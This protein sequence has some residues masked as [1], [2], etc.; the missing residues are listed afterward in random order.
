M[1]TK[2]MNKLM[3]HLNT[4][5]EQ[6]DPLVLHSDD[7]EPHIDIL[8]YEPTE[9]Y[10]FWK[11]TTMGASDFKMNGNNSLGNRNEYM[12]FIDADEDLDDKETLTWYRAQL[13]K[14]A[15]YPVV[16]NSFIS[17]FHSVEW[18]P[19]AG[20]EM[21]CAYLEFPQVIESTGILRCKLGFSKTAICLLAI[22]L[23]KTETEKLLEIGPQQFSEYLYPD[24][25]DEE[26]HFLSQRKR[27]DR[28]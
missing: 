18:S 11:L 19:E 17:V 3:D 2:E 14:V 26:M 28:F 27:N 24:S 16:N 12:M 22:L 9:K 1:K 6:G 4:Y 5:F 20:E 10:H 13:L 7:M 21:V 23:N 25:D 8:R 15:L